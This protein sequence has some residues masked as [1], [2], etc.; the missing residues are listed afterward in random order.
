MTQI[1]YVP[2]H[3]VVRLQDGRIGW[4]GSNT[5]STCYNR[6][7]F[8]N[9]TGTELQPTD[10]VEVLFFPAQLACMCVEQLAQKEEPCKD[11]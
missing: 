9:R 6:I 5:K 11:I 10:E 7:I 2:D 3:S 4:K 8:D 1:R